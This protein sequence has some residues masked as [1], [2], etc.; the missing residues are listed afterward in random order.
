MN[1]KAYHARAFEM[2][3]RRSSLRTG[4]LALAFSCSRAWLLGVQVIRS[5]IWRPRRSPC[6][7]CPRRRPLAIAASLFA[8]LACIAHGPP[9][10]AE[11]AAPRVRV[12]GHAHVEARVT[13][14]SGKVSLSGAVVDDAGR[15]VAGAR[16]VV[17]LARGSPSPGEL[18]RP[19]ATPAPI[20]LALS[21]TFPEACEAGNPEPELEGDERLALATDG[22]ARF[23][24]SFVLPP[25]PY[26]A[27]V[28]SRQTALVDAAT[29]VV[30]FDLTLAPVA[31]RFAP[32]RTSWSLDDD[33]AWVSVVASGD[34]GTPAPGLALALSNETGRV[35]GAA[36]TDASGAARFD[37]DAATLGPPGPGEIRV[38]FAGNARSGAVTEGM[39]I[40][41]RARVV[42]G[43]LEAVNGRVRPSVPEDGIPLTVVASLACASRARDCEGAPGGVV[44]ARV[45][46][47]GVVGVAP[48]VGGTAHLLAAF[49]APPQDAEE[50]VAGMPP[51]ADPRAAPSSIFLRYLPDAPWLEVPA[52][53]FVVRQPLRAPSPWR[54][55]P[56]VLAALAV[57]AWLVLARAPARP[58]RRKPVAPAERPAPA[59]SIEIVHA[60]E[61]ARGWRGRVADAHDGS[62]VARARVAIERR[63]F[64][65]IVVLT[66]ATS[67]PNGEFELHPV[68]ERDGDELVADGPRHAAVRR[69]LPPPGALAVML[70][71]R[72]RAVLDRLVAWAGRQGPPYASPQEPT[73]GH[74]RQVAGTDGAGP[75]GDEAVAQWATAVEEAAYGGA[76][77]DAQAESEVDRLAPPGA[78]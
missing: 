67:D 10:A 52:E 17:S 43:V 69:R 27:R 57:V 51:G 1:L 18:P 16:V 12:L 78:R 22:A 31:L 20:A 28:A 34:P 71:L 58:R 47:E 32:R 7:P 59:A 63:D 9:A 66:E 61:G 11:P 77:V 44:E 65:Q 53:P 70:V 25:D 33:R 62:P 74:V 15:P 37:V 21:K 24:V 49:S 13:R 30:P 41:R 5:R 19:A 36:T 73:P 68:E 6:S 14:D 60:E 3:D 72:K 39:R 42:I 23:C 54:K 8:A 75:A 55:A 4:A 35:L 48:F 40:E 76:P 50:L 38:T 29:A 2:P 56:L 45:A 46:W 26:V 64:E